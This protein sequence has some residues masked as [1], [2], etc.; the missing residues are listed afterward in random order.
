MFGFCGPTDHLACTTGR[1]ARERS[2][3]KSRCARGCWLD[4]SSSQNAPSGEATEET[5][6]RVRCARDAAAIAEI[7]V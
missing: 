5:E 6:P 7:D 2:A 4:A 1:R 3:H